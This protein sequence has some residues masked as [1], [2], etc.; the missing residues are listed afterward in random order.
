MATENKTI[1]TAEHEQQLRQPIDEY[2]GGIQEKINALRADGT[3]RVIEIQSS[4]DNLKR[5]RIYNSEEK[6]ALQSQLQADLEKAKAAS[7]RA[8]EFI[9][10]Q[11]HEGKTE[12]QILDEYA[13]RYYYGVCDGAQPKMAFLIN[14]STMISRVISEATAADAQ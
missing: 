8:A 12:E 5:D 3:D 10:Q 9:L 1:F 7:S 6:A 11:Y 4:L 2:V 13:N 14:T